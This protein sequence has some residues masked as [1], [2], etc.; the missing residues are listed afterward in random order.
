MR[1]RLFLISFILSLP[2]WWGVNVFQEKLENFLFLERIYSNPEFLTAQLVSE[3]KLERLKPIRNKEVA[4]L[5]IAA[6]AG[7]S[8][9]IDREGKER[10]LFEKNAEKPLAIAS[11]TKLMTAKIVLEYYD[12]EKQELIKPLFQLLIESNNQAAIKLSQI[13]GKEAFVEIMNWE[14]KKLGMENSYFANPTGLDP[15]TPKDS[16][17]YSTPKDLVKLAK[18]ITFKR[19]LIW[20]I[21][22]IRE[23]ENIKNTNKLL[24]EVPEIIGGKTG[25][26]PLAGQCLLLVLEAPKQKGYIINIIL[27]SENHFEEMKKLIDWTKNAYRW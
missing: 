10:I 16:L 27:N 21:S 14:V 9:L 7:I 4:N 17:N 18:D 1:I 5:E 26:T 15:Q 22:R 11:L 25:Q 6:K 23:F 13:I 8:V 3:E 20:E 12:I 24:G 19:P 2:F